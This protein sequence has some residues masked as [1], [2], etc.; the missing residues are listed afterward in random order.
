MHAVVLYVCL[1]FDFFYLLYLFHECFTNLNTNASFLINSPAIFLWD[2]TVRHT[3]SQIIELFKRIG[4]T[5]MWIM[6]YAIILLNIGAYVKY[7]IEMYCQYG[8]RRYKIDQSEESNSLQSS[9]LFFEVQIQAKA[10]HPVSGKRCQNKVIMTKI[11][12]SER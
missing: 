12:F 5:K 1:V 9:M 3:F 4:K 11:E 10:Q 7:N 2:N 6:K 8:M